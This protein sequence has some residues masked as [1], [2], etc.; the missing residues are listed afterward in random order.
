MVRN[1][2]VYLLAYFVLC[3]YESLQKEYEK[4]QKDGLVLFLAIKTK[5]IKKYFELQMLIIKDS[6]VKA[7]AL[8]MLISAVF[9][10][11]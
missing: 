2:I 10:F 7:R 6:N 11:F 4:R 3:S 8:G 9:Y 5:E 1:C